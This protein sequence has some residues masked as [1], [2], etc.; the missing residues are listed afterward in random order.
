MSTPAS[1]NESSGH[2]AFAPKKLRE[3]PRI[4]AVSQLRAGSS[5]MS[6]S[7]TGE[8]LP[9]SLKSEAVLQPYAPE[10]GSQPQMQRRRYF[11]PTWI[12][13]LMVVASCAA[14]LIMFAKPLWHGLSVQRDGSSESPPLKLSDR[15]AA[16]FVPT[17]SVTAIAATSETQQPSSGPAQPA[18]LAPL[19]FQ[20]EQKSIEGPV[21]G[22]RQRNSVRNFGAIER[23]C[24]G[25]R[26]KYEAGH[27]CRIQ[28]S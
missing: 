27:R 14:M 28:G 18:Q 22:N 23:C 3:Q 13:W 12:S 19:A 10:A 9:S 6:P 25:A 5:P 15:L 16:I 11:V 26:P 7:H 8:A 2:K 1:D 24:Q 4:P 20:S 17:D 21:Q